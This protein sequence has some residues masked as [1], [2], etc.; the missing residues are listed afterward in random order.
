MT[1]IIASLNQTSG[2]QL[3]KRNDIG[4]R[5]ET[6]L[7]HLVL[8]VEPVKELWFGIETNTIPW[9]ICA[10]WAVG[11]GVVLALGLDRFLI[12]HSRF[13]ELYPYNP[14]IYRIYGFS[15]M[16]FPFWTWA[17]IQVK[18]KRDKLDTLTR[19]FKNS[20]LQSKIGRLPSLISD[21]AL[22]PM[23]RKMRLTNA[24]FPVGKFIEQTKA[25][26]SNLGIFIDA[27]KENRERRS[28]DIIYSHFPMGNEVV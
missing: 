23:I 3:D 2:D 8:L 6:T 15:M 17:W 19:A 13:S 7:K 26:E 16:T 14:F 28:I 1:W 25:I 27:I 12:A 5:I 4:M 18:R 21:H 9:D 24:G 20:G 10:G 11:A 22:D